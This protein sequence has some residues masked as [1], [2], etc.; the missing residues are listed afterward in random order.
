MEPLTLEKRKLRV[1]FIT[2]LTAERS[3][4]ELQMD[5]LLSVPR[6]IRCQEIGIKEAEAL[7]EFPGHLN[8]YTMKTM[9]TGGIDL[10]IRAS[11]TASLVPS[12]PSVPCGTCT[13]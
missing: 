11:A 4:R 13:S 3:H 9:R 7:S 8:K 5:T 6:N 2:H 10:Q 12:L 1:D